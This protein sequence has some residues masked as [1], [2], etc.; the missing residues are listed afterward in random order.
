MD[1][2]MT[3]KNGV[4][5]EIRIIELKVLEGARDPLNFRIIDYL[6]TGES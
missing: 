5:N 4:W 3:M 6:V 1:A 2:M